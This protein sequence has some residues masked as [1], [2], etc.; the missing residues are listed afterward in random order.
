MSRSSRVQRVVGLILHVLVGGL[1]IFAGSGK[2]FG[3]APE[4]IVKKMAEYGLG[5]KL[6]LIGV[7][8][9]VSAILLLTPLTMTLGVLLTSGFWG[10]VICIH[11]AH[12]E[13]IIMPSV[14][15]LM[16]WAGAFLRDPLTF[17][18]F[19]SSRKF[20]TNEVAV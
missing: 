2:A 1:M 16:T 10:G 5:D 7:G 11:M 15:L 18:R 12:G 17:G 4:M 9:M 13:D 3:F 8:E 19:F 20:E 6:V 14:L